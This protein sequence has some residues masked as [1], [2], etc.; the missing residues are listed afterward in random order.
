MKF[1]TYWPLTGLLVLLATIFFWL[2]SWQ[3]ERAAEKV[4]LQEQ[5]NNAATVTQLQDNLTDWTA[6]ELYGQLD[7]TRHLLLENKIYQGRAGVHVLT[8]MT[9]A[10]RSAVLVNRGWLPLPPDRS[11]LPD[12]ATPVSAMTLSGRLGPISQP[13][14]QIGAA[15]ALQPDD[16]PQLIVYPDW[17]RIESALNLQLHPQVLYLDAASEAGFEGRTWTPFTMG[18]DRHRAYALQWYAFALTA[19]IVW[20]VLGFSAGRRSAA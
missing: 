16:W 10:D 4:L 11:S 12:I 5:F 15:Q 6:A 18:P 17:G 8:P 19:L 14:V 7:T 13:G 20:L 1:K 2:G 9:L 3:L